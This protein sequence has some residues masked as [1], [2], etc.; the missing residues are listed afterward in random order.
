MVEQSTAASHA[1]AREAEELARLISRFQVG[2]TGSARAEH[3]PAAPAPRAPSAHSQSASAPARSR[4]A[5]ARK[6]EPQAEEEGWEE[7]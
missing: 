6:L 4:A 3:R 1:L 2:D 5:T 7:F